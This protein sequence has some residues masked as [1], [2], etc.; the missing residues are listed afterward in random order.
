MPQAARGSSRRRVVR[1]PR[2]RRAR[3]LRR[4]S[5]PCKLPVEDLE[6]TAGEVRQLY[7]LLE[8]SQSAP[9]LASAEHRARLARDSEGRTPLY[10][11]V[12]SE[13]LGAQ[14][15]YERHGFEKVGEYGFPV[16]KTVDHEFILKRRC[17]HVTR[18]R[19]R[20]VHLSAEV[21]PRHSRRTSV[22]LASTGFEWDRHWMAASPTGVFMSQRT[23]AAPRA[24]RTR[25]RRGHAHAAR[26]RQSAAASCRC[27][28]KAKRKPREVWKDAHHRARSGRR[29]GRAG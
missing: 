8:A 15:L 23:R 28:R 13:N 4:A 29:R 20:P 19:S 5:A 9:R 21:G 24:H 22:R 2:Q 7:V 18:R 27:S 12:W 3:R 11:G 14:R 26:T 1:D 16:G 17:T 6:P 10:V 25:D